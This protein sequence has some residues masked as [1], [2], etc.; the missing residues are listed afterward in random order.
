MLLKKGASANVLNEKSMA[1]L[2]VA[3]P[4]VQAYLKGT[5]VSIETFLSFSF[6]FLP[7]SHCHL[8]G[9]EFV[10]AHVRELEERDR[11][12]RQRVPKSP[13]LREAFSSFTSGLLMSI[14]LLNGQ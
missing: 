4:S 2:D 3:T 7:F 8:F 6:S 1:P 14:V 13:V 10:Q 9:S 11:V 5:L 12:R